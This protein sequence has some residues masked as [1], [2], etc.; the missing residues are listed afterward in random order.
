[1]AMW[2]FKSCPR[3]GGD[4]FIDRDLDGWYELCL[5]CSH[6]SELKSLA[7]FKEPV[8]IGRTRSK[9]RTVS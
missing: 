8:P 1:M 7:E 9:R 2:K 5:Q 4:V 6:R 3:C